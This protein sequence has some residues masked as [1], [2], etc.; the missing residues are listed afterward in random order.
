MRSDK[1]PWKHG[2]VLVCNNERAAGAGRASC[3]LLR[4]KRVKD[5]LK[6]STRAGGG[7]ASE[8][9]VLNTSCLD[10]CPADG[11]AVA[12]LP[13]D[14]L[15]VVDP[16]KPGDLDALL[17]DVQAHMTTQAEGGGRGLLGR[18]RDRTRR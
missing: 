8:C 14:E 16:D 17:E 6:H 3:G 15:R 12:L 5:E 2:V 1:I 18:I 11:V 13:G 9:R 7:P 10:L 4:G